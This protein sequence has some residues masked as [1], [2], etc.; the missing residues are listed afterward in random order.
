MRAEILKLVTFLLASFP[1]RRTDE[2][3]KRL[4]LEGYVRALSDCDLG[5]IETVINRLITGLPEPLKWAP[6]PPILADM[7]RR[8]TRMRG[9]EAEYKNRLACP[10]PMLS[11]VI[12]DEEAERRMAILDELSEK[13]QVGI[14]ADALVRSG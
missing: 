14:D 12:S 5:D 4:L 6:I 3:E 7:V 11:L 2:I 9:Y 13:L 8:K 1:S 10:V